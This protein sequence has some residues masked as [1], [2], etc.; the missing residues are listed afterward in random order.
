MRSHSPRHLYCRIPISKMMAQAS[1][2]NMPS[3]MP[4]SLAEIETENRLAVAHARQAMDSA[5]NRVPSGVDRVRSLD[6]RRHYHEPER[7]LSGNATK[8]EAESA[9][10]VTWTPPRR[11]PPRQAAIRLKARCIALPLIEKQRLQAVVEKSVSLPQLRSTQQRK[12]RPVSGATGADPCKQG[13]N[14][15]G[16]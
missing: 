7:D 12:T 11:R 4:R 9:H 14:R 13:K 2:R 3:H 15:A 6:I 5:Q 8:R 10:Q 1:E 16:P